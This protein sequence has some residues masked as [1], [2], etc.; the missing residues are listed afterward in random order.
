MIPVFNEAGID[1][2]CGQLINDIDMLV[3]KYKD[4][5]PYPEVDPDASEEEMD[6]AAREFV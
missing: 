5:V 6:H 4:G 2:W 3:H 1:L